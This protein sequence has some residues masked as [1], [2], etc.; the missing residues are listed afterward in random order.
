[1]TIYIGHDD[2]PIVIDNAQDTAR[3]EAWKAQ[4]TAAGKPFAMTATSP[5]PA[6]QG[7]T[8][9]STLL[10]LDY[11][12]LWCDGVWGGPLLLELKI[13]WFARGAIWGR[14]SIDVF[15]F[16]GTPAFAWGVQARAF[17]KQGQN[18]PDATCDAGM[19]SAALQPGVT[20]LDRVIELVDFMQDGGVGFT[21]WARQY[22]G[23]GGSH[24]L[25]PYL[26][27]WI[28]NYRDLGPAGR[29]TI[30]NVRLW[31]APVP[32]NGS[33][34]HV[35]LLYMSGASE[36]N[37]YFES[38]QIRNA[39]GESSTIVKDTDGWVTVMTTPTMPPR[40]SEV[41]LSRAAAARIAIPSRLNLRQ[42]S[43]FR[44]AE[45]HPADVPMPMLTAAAPCT[46]DGHSTLAIRQDAPYVV[47]T[48]F[49]G[50]LLVDGQVAAGPWDGTV[51]VIGG[52][53]EQQWSVP[54]SAGPHVI[55]TQCRVVTPGGSV[56]LANCISAGL[57][58]APEV[59]WPA[60]GHRRIGP[61]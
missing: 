47:G 11:N 29:V 56:E 58:G 34:Y 13:P 33:L 49:Q 1:M 25:M 15:S 8:Q 50:R 61:K 16:T 52:D 28:P 4:F 19:W 59:V 26:G 48:Q 27:G 32:R 14:V 10:G 5:Q 55:A 39:A 35:P 2:S 12:T 9:L 18:V 54:L 57:G 41:A 7:P 3:W 24:V 44:L 37:P 60:P 21:I 46:M 53:H 22:C 17:G 43:R 40:S 36:M 45:I 42:R 20:H 23:D 51:S 6:P 31:L 38:G 30:G